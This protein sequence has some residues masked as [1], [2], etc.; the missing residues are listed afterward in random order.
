MWCAQEAHRFI[1]KGILFDIK[2]VPS[3]G[4]LLLLSL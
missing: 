4:V 1:D 3:Y 2:N